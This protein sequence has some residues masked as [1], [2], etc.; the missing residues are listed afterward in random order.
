[1]LQAQRFC[2]FNDAMIRVA[3][4]AI[5]NTNGEI[6][7]AKRPPHKHKGD[8]WEFPG[9]KIEA[10]ETDAAALVRELQEELNITATL[11][12]PLISL[13]H[14]YPEQSVE[15]VV[16]RVKAFNGELRANEQQPLT[17]VKPEAMHQFAM[18]EADVPIVNAI[19]LPPF[20]AITPSMSDSEYFYKACERVLQMHSCFL[21]LRD[22][23]IDDQLYC[24]IAKKLLKQLPDYQS[25][26]ILNRS[27]EL[28]SN[29]AC[30]GVHLGS[31][32]LMRLSAEQVAAKRTQ[33][34]LSASC[35]NETELQ[36]AHN[37][38]LDYCFLSPVQT[39]ASHPE[40][41]ALG[42]EKFKEF[43]RTI[44]LP[45]YALGGL[46]TK[47]I[48]TAKNYGAQGVAGITAFW[49]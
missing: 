37:I 13:V 14:H 15:L 23:A 21:Q 4:A 40:T 31:V 35:H 1:M 6:L 11:Y 16:F 41:S 12:E 9:G 44:A 33:R 28:V 18:P 36:H 49:G 19:I 7:L 3:A 47:D 34:W 45:I 26:I 22:H 32:Q 27:V 38:G 42:W 46:S 39:T 10:G 2:E 29:I 48:G 43:S 8:L 25:R 5:E 24:S 30:A 20:I 17:W